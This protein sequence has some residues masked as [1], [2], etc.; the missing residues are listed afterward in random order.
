MLYCRTILLKYA[1]RQN[2]NGSQRCDDSGGGDLWHS[3]RHGGGRSRGALVAC[4]SVRGAFAGREH[5]SRSVEL[6]GTSGYVR[7]EVG[8]SPF[9][10]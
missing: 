4:G 10:G 8:T 7:F 2:E 1:F 3:K 9:L 6:V 5:E